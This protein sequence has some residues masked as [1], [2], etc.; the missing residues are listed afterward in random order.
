LRRGGDL[1]QG[2]EGAADGT[3]RVRGR[4]HFPVAFRAGQAQRIAGHRVLQ[5][6]GQL[7][8]PVTPL[9]SRPFYPQAETYAILRLLA[10]SPWIR[11]EAKGRDRHSQLRRTELLVVIRSSTSLYV[12]VSR[13]L[14][15]R[16][17]VLRGALRLLAETQMEPRRGSRMN[18]GEP[19]TN[20][21]LPIRTLEWSLASILN[22]GANSLFQ[23]PFEFSIFETHKDGLIRDLSEMRVDYF[24]WSKPRRMVV[25]KDEYS[26]R[27]ATQ[28]D[29]I[30]AL[31]L[32]AIVK[33]VGHM[34]EAQR[35][36]PNTVFSHRFAER[37]EVLYQKS[38][39][40]P[41]FWRE[42]KSR[43]KEVR[44]V[45]QTDISDFYSQISHR[46]VL[47]Q[48]ER[49]RVPDRLC[50]AI[51]GFLGAF[52]VEHARGIPVGP[53][54]AHMLAELSLIRADALIASRGQNF[55]RYI[56]DYHFF[57]RSE[58]EAA[59]ALFDAASVIRGEFGLALNRGKTSVEQSE[60]IV[61][62]A[63]MM[64][65]EETPRA[66]EEAFLQLLE[67]LGAD[68]DPYESIDLEAAKKLAPEA[69][70]E[71]AME[72][73]LSAHLTAERVDYK[74]LGWLLRRFSQ[75]GAP[76]GV[77]YVLKN[78]DKFAPV[79]GDAAQYLAAAGE[80]WDR[81]LKDL[82]ASIL[83]HA[84]S[85]IVKKSPY[86]EMILYGLFSLEA[87]LNHFEGLAKRFGRL[88][89]EARRE[90]ILAA[91]AAGSIDW[92]HEVR[93]KTGSFDAWMRRAFVYS[94]EIL[95]A[96]QQEECLDALDADEQSA[97][98]VL[99]GA[100]LADRSIIDV[101][102][103]REPK[104]PAWAAK[105]LMVAKTRR[106]FVAERM[107]ALERELE[108][109]VYGEV[110]PEDLLVATWNLRN[111]GGGGFGF[112]ERLAESFMYIAR[113][114]LGFDLVALQEVR[115][116]ANVDQLLSLLGAGWEK[117]I[118]GEAVGPSGNQEM[119]AF[120][121]RHKRIEFEG[122][123]EQVVLPSSALIHGR[124]QFARPPFVATFRT[125]VKGR[126]RARSSTI[127][128]CTAHVYFGA[129]RGAKYER[130]VKEIE[131]LVSRVLTRAKKTGSTAILLGD[132]NVVNLEDATMRPL[133]RS[134]MALAESYLSPTNV[135]RNRFYTQ[136]A[137]RPTQEGPRLSRAG[138]VEVFN[139]A[140]RDGDYTSYLKEMRA[141]KAWDT[142]KRRSGKVRPATFFKRWRTYQL[143]DH[144][145]VWA[146]F[147]I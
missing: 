118:C 91:R 70:S 89:A 23:L 119:S 37:S 2:F 75:V 45:V 33:L 104:G 130:R 30:D 55:I 138:V 47:M 97:D 105:R 26:F 71:E 16:S 17:T 133:K 57:C 78:F 39:G 121:Y 114:L 99:L 98:S 69:I 83:Q 103:W 51:E 27:L 74:Q 56:D 25:P 12:L 43:A 107:D 113:V 115:S 3:H 52:G 5:P 6:H 100:L 38:V 85:S 65:R 94:S 126:E 81:G 117:V 11:A 64:I 31:I 136:I 53:H 137:F 87:D 24:R 77:P 41:S 60:A 63:R 122:R 101:E 120:L 96:K 135:A 124:H 44:F 79:I 10:A 108:A 62:K 21:R 29:P 141:S 102:L 20:G 4:S 48:L 59:I 112:G 140:F 46:E 144:L 1:D 72:E 145:P 110:G 68:K 66:R 80:H 127:T 95:P 19:G 129:T 67:K 42:A 15:V 84:D 116:E 128:A 9:G 111:F 61:E 35:L 14:E 13:M 86:L 123:V 22:H 109:N 50:S 131:A 125:K 76:G 7:P 134:D 92:L 34:I 90:I 93:K 132:L 8:P 18:L 146:H 88:S 106:E 139:F 32:T 54:A 142:Q 82:G 49:C 143:S 40:W 36:P 147:R 58:E 28:L 73:I